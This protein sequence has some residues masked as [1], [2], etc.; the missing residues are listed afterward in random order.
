MGL[1][2]I[3]KLTRRFKRFFI[4]FCIVFLFFSSA[5]L[6]AVYFFNIP[7]A[8][9]IRAI[10]E[11]IRKSGDSFIKFVQDLKYFGYRFGSDRIGGYKLVIKPSDYSKLNNSLPAPT[12]SSVLTKEYKEYVPAKMTIGKTTYK[13]EV[14][15]RGETSTHW[16]WPKKS[17]RIKFIEP[18]AYNGMHTMD[19]IVPHDRGYSM[20]MF[21]NY[22]AK[23]LGLKVPY[24]DFVNL[25]VNGKNN[26][27]YFLVSHWDKETIERMELGSDT[28]FYGERSINEPIFEDIKYWQKYLSNSEYS[29]DDYSDLEYLISLVRDSSQ[30][31]FEKKIFSII[32]KNNFF[33]WWVH[34]VLSGSNHQDWAHNTRLYFDKSLGK[35][36]FLPWDLEGALLNEGLF[37]KYNPL[38]SRIIKNNEWR[39]EMMQTLWRYVKDEKNLKDDLAYIDD[40]NERI[41]ISFYKDRLKEFNNSYV[42]SQM[43]LYRNIIE[44]NFYYIKDTIKNPDVRARVYE[45]YSPSIPLMIDIE[46]KT[47]ASVILKQIKIENLSDMRVYLDVNNNILDAQDSYIGYLD[48]TGTLDAG[49]MMFSEV[50]AKAEL[51]GNYDTIEITPKHYNLFFV[52]NYKNISAQEKIILNIENGVTKD[53]VRINYDYFDQQIH[54]NRDKMNL[55]IDEFVRQNSFFVKTGKNEITLNSAFIYKD[56]IIPPGLKVIIAPGSNIFLAKDASI[57]SYSSILAEGSAVGKI[58]FKPLIPGEPW[59]SL[60]VISAPKSIFKYVYFT[61]GKDESNMGLFASGMLSLYGT[62]AEITNSEFSLACGDDALNIKNAKAEVNNSLFYKNSFD[63]IDFDFVKKGKVEGNQFIEN[64]NDGI[65]ISG[66]YVDIKNNIIK[67]SGDKCISVGEKS[68]PLISGNTLDG[69]EMG[70]GT[71]DLSEPIIIDNIIINNKVGISAYLKKEIFGGAFP[72]VG[73]NTFTNNEKDTEIDELSKIIEYKQQL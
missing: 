41:K 71:K 15:Y 28:N 55:G 65:D 34:Q 56:I 3:S 8:V 52:G 23:K 29:E 48:K 1:I 7:S 49:Q 66:S 58:N 39:A 35:F 20:E 16:L 45:N 46:V 13:V 38:I 67:K 61:G 43:A 70:I 27:V 73:N 68:Y 37:A 36:I 9:A 22:R 54:R 2:R 14:G 17:W 42:D 21:N 24:S 47:P 31:E 69:C 32:D 40:L 18:H 6:A 72:K 30:E 51:R 10:P 59:G 25:E 62:D 26:G 50:D 5:V 44:K 19:L 33:N 60:A 63:A 57:I 64:G 53:T 4:V 11:P 12:G